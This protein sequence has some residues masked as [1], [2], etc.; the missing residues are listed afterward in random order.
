M[1]L[2]IAVMALSFLFIS[3]E[4]PAQSFDK[5]MN[6][7][8]AGTVRIAKA[9]GEKTV[10]RE[11]PYQFNGTVH[12]SVRDGVVLDETHNFVRTGYLLKN[13]RP[14]F[15]GLSMDSEFALYE[16]DSYFIKI[17]VN[18]NDAWFMQKY[19]KPLGKNGS[20]ELWQRL[21]SV[22]DEASKANSH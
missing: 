11:K 14:Q 1:R 21:S 7:Q 6:F 19:N 8:C 20:R 12:L 3:D 18:D 5:T 22:E 15:V 17:Q 10:W 16:G 13:G 4:Y 9:K 2:L